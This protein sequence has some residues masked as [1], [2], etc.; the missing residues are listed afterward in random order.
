MPNRGKVEDKP[1][2]IVR[3]RI[4]NKG[5]FA[6][7]DIRKGERVVQYVGEWVSKEEGDRRSEVQIERAE[8]DPSLGEVYV[9]ELNDDYDIDGNVPENDARFINHSCDPNCEADIVKDEIWIIASKDVK[10]G[11]EL[12]YDYSYGLDDFEEYPCKCGSKNCF[13]YILDGDLWDEGR[14]VLKKKGLPCRG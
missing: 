4:H 6:S 14:R 7:R 9:F 5:I 10:K 11:E 12:T 2:R 3:S 8:K 1:Y 13:G